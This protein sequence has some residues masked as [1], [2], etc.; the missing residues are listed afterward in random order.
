MTAAAPA[1]E[2][3]IKRLEV[4]ERLHR[5]LLIVAASGLAPTHSNPPR[6][7]ERFPNPFMT[8]SFS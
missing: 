7:S 6:N 1:M 5:K 4:T 8:A 2:A 3:L